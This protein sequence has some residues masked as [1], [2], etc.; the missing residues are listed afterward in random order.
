MRFLNYLSEEYATRGKAIIG[1]KPGNDIT[2]EIFVNPT[3]KELRELFLDSSDGAVRY[4]AD[5]K[6]KKLYVW[7]SDY[8][9]LEGLNALHDMIPDLKTGGF[10]FL[11]TGV[12]KVTGNKLRFDYA[13]AAWATAGKPWSVMDDKWLNKWFD[14]PYTK[15]FLDA[16]HSRHA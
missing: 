6:S 9:H 11:T 12:A 16:Y 13:D 2:F 14:K 5:F 3:S 1:V 4:V 15:T 8:I 7:K 10:D